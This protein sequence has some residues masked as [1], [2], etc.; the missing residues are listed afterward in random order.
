MMKGHMMLRFLEENKEIKNLER[1]FEDV[2]FSN[3]NLMSKR[4]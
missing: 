1:A 2:C 3:G 4:A